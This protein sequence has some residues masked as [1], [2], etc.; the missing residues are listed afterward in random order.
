MSL[1]RPPAPVPASPPDL[2]RTAE[3][4]NAHVSQ[5][6]PLSMLVP[7]GLQ[8]F[9][10]AA[11]TPATSLLEPAHWIGLKFAS[12]LAPSTPLFLNPTKGKPVPRAACG[13]W[14]A[15]FSRDK[16]KTAR[17][18]YLCAGSPAASRRSAPA[19]RSS[20]FVGRGF[21]PSEPGAHYPS[22]DLRGSEL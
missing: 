9:V 5:L 17:S 8:D 7:R 1:Y 11:F 6:F 12:V 2:H 22:L 20:R 3:T 13:L 19:F 10:A 4:P 15:A 16:N 18:A 14:V 21:L